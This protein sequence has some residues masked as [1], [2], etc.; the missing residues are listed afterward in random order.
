[1]S[2]FVVRGLTVASVVATES[3]FSVPF[4]PAVLRYPLLIRF[5]RLAIDGVTMVGEV[6]STTLPDPVTARLV[7]FL[8]PSVPT[9]TEAVRPE[10]RRPANVGVASE[11]MFW[12][13]VR[14]TSPVVG[15]AVT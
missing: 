1:M 3:T 5:A 13:V 10:S 2:P 9:G 8:L 4:P 11:L 6:A 14:I 15:D 7:R 12:G